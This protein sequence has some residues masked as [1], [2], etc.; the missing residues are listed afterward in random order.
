MGWVFAVTS[1]VNIWCASSLILHIFRR[2]T[3]VRFPFRSLLAASFFPVLAIVYGM[4]WWTVWR[5]KPSAKGWG[6]AASFAYVLIS[7][8][9]IIFSSRSAPGSVWSL[10]PLGVAGLAIFLRPDAMNLK[11]GGSDSDCNPS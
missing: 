9:G 8:W 2:Y 1:I 11:A 6:I 4:A 3:F 5:G 7:F 10:L